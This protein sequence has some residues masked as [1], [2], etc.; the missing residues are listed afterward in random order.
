MTMRHGSMS[1]STPAWWPTVIPS[2]VTVI[3]IAWLPVEFVVKAIPPSADYKENVGYS[4]F[5]SL[6]ILR[7]YGAPHFSQGQVGG[8]THTAFQ[9]ALDGAGLAQN[10]LSSKIDA[11][12]VRATMIFALLGITAC[13]RAVAPLSPGWMR[14]AF[15]WSLARIS[16]DAGILLVMSTYEVPAALG[17]DM[18]GLSLNSRELPVP[19]TF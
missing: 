4:Y 19:G 2:M 3:S 9:I 12:S 13:L 18:E 15:I 10:Q 16:P 8:L 7:F 11:C 6:S 5:Y 1:R 17:M 14:Q